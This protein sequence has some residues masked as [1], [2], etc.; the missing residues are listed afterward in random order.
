[1]RLRN[2]LG[3]GAIALLVS[4]CGDDGGGEGTPD[5][6]TTPDSG[7]PD[8]G[9][10]DANEGPSF[11]T[12]ESGMVFFERI[13]SAEGP[14]D[15]LIGK[16]TVNLVE[17]LT[18]AM[19]PAPGTC[20]DAWYETS[21]YWPANW[22][23]ETVSLDVGEVTIQAEGH[24]P[25]VAEPYPIRDGE[26]QDRDFLSRQNDKAIA[27]VI[28]GEDVTNIMGEGDMFWDVSTSGGTYPETTW[29]D[30]LYMP[31]L[32]TLT[33]SPQEPLDLTAVNEDGDLVLTY[34][35]GDNAY[36]PEGAL[37]LNFVGFAKPPTED[38]DPGELYS[39]TVCLSITDTITI[40]AETVEHLKTEN[41]V[42]VVRGQLVHNII[43][44][45]EDNPEAGR[46]DLVGLNCFA[47]SIAPIEN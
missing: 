38:P 1:M 24:E 27:A 21:E 11:A 44:M 45:E 41:V 42:A 12:P 6:G 9:E 13:V 35:S 5:S 28:M 40:P 31:S 36:L 7:Q 46:F 3:Y 14:E 43:Y 19:P 33:P 26:E 34:D 23:A 16:I 18:A 2:W 47:N 29:E 17:P 10:P 8:S 32:P 25:F 20:I 39:V 37:P 30:K 22:P 15:A 4:A